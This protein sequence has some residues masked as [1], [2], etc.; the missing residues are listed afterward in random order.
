MANSA[1]LKAVAA[2]EE[3]RRLSKQQL[4]QAHIVEK[5]VEI[6]GIGTIQVRSLSHKLRQELREKAGFGT[7][8][9]SDEKLTD[10][11]IVHSII[12]PDLSESDIPA[13]HGWSTDVYDA[14]V[15]EL[16]LLNMLG[17]RKDLKKGSSQTQNSD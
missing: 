9:F 3:Q 7:E 8:E 1:E 13:L 5:E 11:I 6:D 12:D 15:T 17:Q 4:L 14:V 2:Q 10:L 16:T